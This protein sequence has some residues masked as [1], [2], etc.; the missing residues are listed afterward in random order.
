ME[1]IKKNDIAIKLAK[2]LIEKKLTLSCAESCTGGNIA[3]KI[4]LVSGASMFF[5]G[6]IVSY[7]NEIKER[8]LKVSG[9]DLDKYG[10]VSH[11]VAWQMAVN[12]CKI[13]NT[14]FALATTGLAGPNSDGSSTEIGTVYIALA[15]KQGTVKVEK[16]CL[17]YPRDKFIDIV[18]DKALLMLVNVLE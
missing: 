15:D 11:T 8:V 13:M 7:C 16:H 1:E 12:V 6:S 5:K 14:D 18:S 17:L 4:T 9:V 2:L 10:P 3:H